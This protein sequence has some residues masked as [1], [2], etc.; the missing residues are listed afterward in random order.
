M[1]AMFNFM[2]QYG[3]AFLDIWNPDIWSIS[4]LDVT[5]KVFFRYD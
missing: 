1:T 2:G 4:S 3:W 5:M